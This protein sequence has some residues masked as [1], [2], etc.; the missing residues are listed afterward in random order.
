MYAFSIV[1]THTSTYI[2]VQSILSSVGKLI[3][4]MGRLTLFSTVCFTGLTR[5]KSGV[6]AVT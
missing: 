3:K 6:D 4:E 2:T 1:G 5:A